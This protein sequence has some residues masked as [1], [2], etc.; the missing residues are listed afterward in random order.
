MLSLGIQYCIFDLQAK[1]IWKTV[2]GKSLY[3]YQICN[4]EMVKLKK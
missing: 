3:D 1:Q 4:N 2:E